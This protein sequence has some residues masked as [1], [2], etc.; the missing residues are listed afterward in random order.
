MRHLF[1]IDPLE[2]LNI[3]KDS[4]LLMAHTLAARG[5]EV[6]ILLAADCY[7]IQRA[8]LLA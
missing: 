8:G 3:K 5:E 4:S 7:F 1:L 2:K 6:Y